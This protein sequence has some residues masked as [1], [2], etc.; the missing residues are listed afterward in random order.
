M[1]SGNNKEI[2]QGNLPDFFIL[3]IGLVNQLVALA[4]ESRKSDA[5]A[6]TLLGYDLV[7]IKLWFQIILHN[8][9]VF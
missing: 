3:R 1:L 7:N 8:R 2:G 4:T 6:V 5:V 9:N